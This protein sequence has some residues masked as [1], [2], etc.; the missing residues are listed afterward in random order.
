MPA[1]WVRDL[2]PGNRNVEFKEVAGWTRPAARNAT[3]NVGQ[4]TRVTE[5]YIQNG[6]LRV[7]IQPQEAVAAGAQW[8]L[9]SAKALAWRSS[10]DTV[11]NVQAGQHQVE[12]K[13]LS[14]WM[15]PGNQTATITAGQTT[16]LGGEY[17]R[18][19]G[20]LTVT[21][22]PQGVVTVGGQW[23]IGNS[24]WQNSGA[25]VSN[26]TIGTHLVEFKDVPGWTKP[27]QIPINIT[28]GQTS[29]GTGMYRK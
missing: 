23:R 12:F 13:D 28:A 17:R 16:Q 24:P 8:Q 3:V 15:K 7:N 2:N 25:T 10:G 9:Q 11:P 29:Q 18:A 14:G 6:A 27:G 19:V 4:D 21:I 5:T 20:S 1:F 26:L 22:Q